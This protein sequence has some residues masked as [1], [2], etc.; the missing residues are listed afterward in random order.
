VRRSKPEEVS[1]SVVLLDIDARHGQPRSR[2]SDPDAAEFRNVVL[3]AMTG[4]G[5]EGG[6]ATFA[7]RDSIITV[8]P[9]DAGALETLLISLDKHTPFREFLRVN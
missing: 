4:W 9:A 6:S 7:A 3:I 1:P 5:Q 2:A 8:K